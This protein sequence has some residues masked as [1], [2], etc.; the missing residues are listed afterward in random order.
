MQFLHP[1]I[2]WGLGAITIPI[3]V[4]LFNFRKFRRVAFSNVAFLKEIKQ[5]TQ[6]KS[7]IK[8]FLILL[9]RMLAITCI[10][11]AFAQPY[12]PVE[13]RAVEMG[14]QTVSIYIDNSFSMEAE[15][16][17]GQLLELA[18]NKA[19]EIV[20][21]YGPTDQFQ[22]LTN[23]FEGRH[24]RLV[25]QE[26]ALER[27]EEVELSSHARMLSE[28]LIRQKDALARGEGDRRSA[29]VLSDLQRSTHDFE[30]IQADSTVAVRMV[31]SGVE[32]GS[33]IYIDSVWF[34]TPVR[35]LNQSER[36]NIR[37]KNTRQAATENIPLRLTINGQQKAIGSFNL[38]PGLPTDT[39]LYFSH[40]APGIKQ[41][42]LHLDDYPVTFDDD[43]FFSYDV[44][45][46]ISV[47]EL[48]APGAGTYF[49]KIFADDSYY[50]YERLLATSVDYGRLAEINLIILNE[51]PEISSGLASQLLA[52]IE[53]GGSVLAVPGETSQAEGYNLLFS[54]VGTPPI[55]GR[56][57]QRLKV[58]D[59]RLD[60]PLY[61]GIF[62]RLP[63]NVDLPEAMVWFNRQTDNRSGEEILLALQNGVPFLSRKAVGQG[64][65]YWCAAPLAPSASTFAQHAFFVTSALRIAEF[66]QPAPPLYATIGNESAITLRNIDEASDQPYRMVHAAT[67]MEFLP[68]SR[69]ISGSTELFPR[70]DIL[71]AGNYRIT[72]NGQAVGTASYNFPRNESELET[73]APDALRATLDAAGLPQ[74]SVLNA[75][76]ETLQKQVNSLDAGFQLWYSF[77]IL[78]LIFLA[79][80]VLL[81]KFWRK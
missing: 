66:S 10:V 31:P 6:S 52:F 5:D 18:K 11:F 12:F 2:L 73:I 58:S 17:E 60:H 74:I 13:D 80:E 77:I 69:R 26:E 63:Q 50:T 29:F 1:E 9:M 65:F 42:V 20:E 81:I 37:I 21:V 78:A 16:E 56:N 8:H 49:R 70:Q 28:V 43:F 7:R 36:L 32:N 67:G 61:T 40:T 75:G 24:Q 48:H 59:I 25:N 30:N 54:S 4:H 51:L 64:Q 22:L 19:L 39:A 45:E 79:L 68:E 38:Q 44:A 33:N 57:E 55:T 71:E 47:M 62:E 3:I 14:N 23:D 72:L 53:N 76:L 34:E 27:I 35:Q 15:N 41:A 46:Q